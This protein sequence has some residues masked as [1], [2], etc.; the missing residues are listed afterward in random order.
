MPRGA[1][2]IPD[3]RLEVLQNFV[4]KFTA[5]PELIFQNLFPASNSPSSTI[6]WESHTGTRGMTPFK[7]PGAK[8]PMS[9]PLGIAKH[10][11]ECAFWGEMMYFD[12][13]FL[14][15][16][17]K[18]GT[19]NTY[20]D[21]QS[22]LA[23]E[24]AGMTN[25]C[26]RRKEWMWAKALISGT[27]T[28]SETGG[29]KITVN[30]ELPSTHS[31]TLGT[32]YKWQNGSQ[33]DILSD[34]ITGKRVIADDCGGQVDW[35]FCNSYV[36]QYMAQ[37]PTILTLLQKTAFGQGNLFE[38]NLNKLVAVNPK[39]IGSLLDIPN[40]VVFDEKYEVRTYLTAAVIANSTTVVSVANPADFEAGDTL[41]FYDVSAGTSEDETVA[42]VD[43]EAGTI[44]V[45]SAP[46][47]SYKSGED[48][49]YT[50]KYFVPSDKFVMVA[51]RVEGQP[52]AEFKRA[53]FGLDRHYGLKTDRKEEWDP[54]GVFIRVQDKG[55]PVIYQRDAIYTLDVN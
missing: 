40:L 32:D 38:G 49:V 44:T 26:Y 46:A 37:D 33:R 19:E 5:P 17:R 34:I 21:A 50:R 41:T 39:I 4:T 12:E 9:Y 45:S 13:E 47:T 48:Y 25:R 30:Y 29:T 8:T 28:Y 24:L 3:L 53:P 14:N 35:A 20:Q 23:R 52:I 42:S 54:E 16:L 22:R 11:A 18:E 6:K 7:P 43:I 1:A 51:S 27:F 31:V 36:L 15:N 10:S 55:L 2:D